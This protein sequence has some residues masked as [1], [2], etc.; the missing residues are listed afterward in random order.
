MLICTLAVSV[1]GGHDRRVLKKYGQDR[2]IAAAEKKRVKILRTGADEKRRSME[3][4]LDVVHLE[5]KQ[6]ETQSNALLTRLAL[7]EGNAK[8]LGIDPEELSSLWSCLIGGSSESSRARV[9]DPRGT[10]DGLFWMAV[11]L[12]EIDRSSDSRHTH[13][14]RVLQ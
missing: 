3:E 2:V 4:R 11:S 5:N 9:G 10:A 13:V 14:R 1:A 8:R 12:R 7:I 6:L